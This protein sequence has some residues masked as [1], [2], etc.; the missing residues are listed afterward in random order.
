MDQ[1]TFS[2]WLRTF[3][4]GQGTFSCGPPASARCQRPFSFRQRAFCSSPRPSGSSP[5]PS[6]SSPRYSSSSRSTFCGTERSI[7]G[8][9]SAA[10]RRTSPL[11]STQP[12]KAQFRLTGDDD[13]RKPS[14]RMP[15]AA[16]A[17]RR[18]A[19]GNPRSGMKPSGFEAG[20]IRA[21]AQTGAR[22]GERR[23]PSIRSK[24][25]GAVEDESAE[26]R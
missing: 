15:P 4:P 6:G 22:E 14:G 18:W 17:Q 9:Q 12:P 23:A 21:T 5:R 1:R 25:K 24:T 8:L 19:K 2:R 10:K 7:R 3:A 20:T 11:P 16:L 13:F 26:F